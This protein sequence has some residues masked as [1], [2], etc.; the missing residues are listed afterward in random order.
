MTDL[1]SCPHCGSPLEGQSEVCV[2]CHLDPP[3]KRAVREA[4]TLGPGSQFRPPSPAELNAHLEG[5]QV[6]RLLGRGGMGAV[7]LGR[8]QSL[9]REV[10]IKVLPPEVASRPGF[11]ERFARE[12][13]LLAKLSHPHIVGVH[14]VIVV[15]PY[16]M[17]VMELVDGATLRDVM[18][19][20]KLS[21]AEALEIIP[22]L[23]DA[24]AYAHRRG[25]IHR[26]IKPE[27]LLF[28][29]D[30]R[31][32]IADF[33]LAKMVSPVAASPQAKGDQVSAPE[34]A[35]SE[36]ESE[37]PSAD[38]LQ[39][40]H[41]LP[42]DDLT[43]GIVGTVHYMAPE[44][45]ERP[46]DVD[47]RAD[48]YGLGVVFYELLTGRLPIGRFDPPSR[49][50]HVDVRLDEVVL[51]ALDHYPDRRYETADALGQAVTGASSGTA[52]P[53]TKSQSTASPSTEGPAATGPTTTSPTTASPATGSPRRSRVRDAYKVGTEKLGKWAASATTRLKASAEPASSGAG[54]WDSGNWGSR[55]Q[56]LGHFRAATRTARPLEYYI[57]IGLIPA[58][59]LA[60]I[61]GLIAGGF[62]DSTLAIIPMLAIPIA[63]VMTRYARYRCDARGHNDQAQSGLNTLLR[64]LW[65]PIFLGVLFL[66]AGLA[67]ANPR[68][69]SEFQVAVTGPPQSPPLAFAWTLA[70]IQLVWWWALAAIHFAQPKILAALTS[71][72]LA[73][74]SRIRPAITLGVLTC[75][76]L[77][78]A[79]L[80]PAAR[81]PQVTPQQAIP[82]AEREGTVASGRAA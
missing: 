54:S 13:R 66:P 14:D 16:A 78:M 49:Q 65:S 11:K 35:K 60:T 41:D 37:S 38:K 42:V 59:L 46:G 50:V 28:D 7:Y 18:S 17:L 76:L 25:V 40:G 36:S 70:S 30:G 43:G 52:K 5:Y 74:K 57:A 27:N 15:G 33:G 34:S 2:K 62:D 73:G 58:V 29:G 22:H 12:G 45:Y 21:P 64:I 24:L 53:A 8:Q 51:R 79:L 71:P 61:V 10:A 63:I 55:I 19:E 81:V 23:C 4:V 9:D 6:E 69:M 20:G 44:Q 1:P 82:G 39:A 68:E 47:H 80:R 31:I 56:S 77:V 32:K 26:D 3:A 67:I 75:A 48:I 72:V